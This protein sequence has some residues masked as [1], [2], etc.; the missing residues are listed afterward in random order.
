[1]TYRDI[2]DQ[3]LGGVGQHGGGPHNRVAGA[4]WLHI[5]VS[6]VRAADSFMGHILSVGCPGG[7]GLE[8]GRSRLREPAST[9]GPLL[10]HCGGRDLHVKAGRTCGKKEIA[11]LQAPAG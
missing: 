9:Q 1:M 4:H 2:S 10:R 8:G 5:H 7:Q 11:E 3:W 6:R